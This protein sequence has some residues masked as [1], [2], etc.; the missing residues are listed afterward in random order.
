MQAQSGA[1]SMASIEATGPEVEAVVKKPGCGIE[2]EIALYNTPTQTVIA[3]VSK[4]VERVA[5]YF[6]QGN[7]KTKTLMVG[8]AFHSHYLDGML[9]EFRAVVRSVQFD[10]PLDSKL[11]VVSS[12]DGRVVEAGEMQKPEYWVDQVRSPVR[13]ID[14]MRTLAARGVDVFIEMGPQPV[15]S[16]MGAACLAEEDNSGMMEWLPSLSQNKDGV[17]TLLNGLSCLRLR[18]VDID[19][20]AYFAPLGCRRVQLPTYA[21]QRTFQQKPAEPDM[22]Y[23]R[24]A[25]G[26]TVKSIEDFEF[27][28]SWIP[29]K[30]KRADPGGTWGVISLSTSSW[31]KDVK[32]TL[33]QAGIQL[34][35][36][37]TLDQSEAKDRI[38]CLWDGHGEVANQTRD[39]I[40][41]ALA[42]LQMAAHM[43]LRCP[44][45]WV[46]R[47][48][49][50][51]GS[52]SDDQGM[53]PNSGSLLWGLMR[54]A[55]NEHPE[56]SLRLV[57]LGQ[58]STSEGMIS[59]L[60][61]DEEPE[62]VVRQGQ[63][64]VS[65][66]ERVTV[67]EKNPPHRG[68][69]RSNG[70]VLITGGLGHLGRHVARWLATKH[71]V[72]DMVLTSRHGMEAGIAME[73]VAELSA[74]NVAV[75]VVT[76]DIANRTTIASIMTAFPPDRPLRGVVHAAGVSDSGVLSSLTPERCNK[77]ISP[78]AH[79]AWL[80]HKATKDMELDF[81][82]MFS[83][84][85]GVMGMP[86]LANYAAAN[87]FLD[88]LA[89]LRRAQGLPATSVAFGTL[90]GDGGMA[91]RLGEGARSHLEQFGLDDL[92]AED[93]LELMG[94]AVLSGRPLTV[95]A[96]LDLKR[97]HGFYQDQGSGI[98]PLV[99]LLLA[100]Q[101]AVA[102]KSRRNLREILGET[103][104]TDHPAAMLGMVRETVAKAL[105]FTHVRDVDVDRSLRDIGV[106]SLTAVQIR[107][108]LATLTG[109]TIPVNIALLHP[110]L[111]ALSRALLSQF[112]AEAKPSPSPPNK[113][114]LDIE[115]ICQGSLDPSFRF[116]GP[117]VN[118]KVKSVFL[119]GV[120]GFVGAFILHPL[121]QRGITVHCLVRASDVPTA[122]RR[123]LAALKSYSISLS[124]SQKSNIV[125]IPG[126]VSKPLFGLLPETFS[127]LSEK[128]DAICHSAG[129]VDWMRPFEEYV[130]PNIVSTHE[131]LRLA[132][133][134]S[135]V[136]PSRTSKT[137][138]K[139]MKA[140][141]KIQIHQISTISTLPFHSATNP[142]TKPTDP[143][144]GYGTSKYLAERLVSGARWRGA[145]ATIYRL[146]YASACS[147]S[148]AFRRDRGDFLHGLVVGGLELGLFP[149]FSLDE[150]GGD[151]DMEIVLPVDYLAGRV[152][153]VMCGDDFEV[154]G[155]SEGVRG[156]DWDFR[157]G[158]GRAVGCNDFFRT[159]AR[160]GAELGFGDVGGKRMEI[161]RFGEW[162]RRALSYAAAH[163][164]SQLARISAVLDGYTEDTAIT[165]FKGERAGRNVFGGEL[166]PAPVLDEAW[167]R[168][169]LGCIYRDREGPIC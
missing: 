152:V 8:H 24:G 166:C 10:R 66:M 60:S 156:R 30:T 34:T 94:R 164:K 109:L 12:L 77:T 39:E 13:F 121:L 133:C 158:K 44:L 56:L 53:T 141:K 47:H 80:L 154:G 99:R 3:G 93:G 83:S 51:T 131:I 147:V 59:A 92:S 63:V 115:G 151:V 111:C 81:F 35:E 48:A 15:L 110:N 153:S 112:Q 38:I 97:L 79:G 22:Q 123:I 40:A 157:S 100:D 162:K 119:T 57:D 23:R 130:G 150:K 45:V 149:F 144:H 49:V 165:M 61:S 9:D 160:V 146:P 145:D 21:F 90:A 87:T 36:V 29:T 32:A 117:S 82:V 143:E 108:H 128:I 106:D 11:R 168:R 125:P 124:S 54:T 91:A 75:T 98:P 120:T 86:G 2:V 31:A 89:H 127:D 50:G 107:N 78:K 67:P 14:G 132:S 26:R 169:Y 155:G 116:D 42:Q 69:V 139:E 136:S 25:N 16:G 126:D 163:P 114:L 62:C 129:L 1:Y 103:N 134:C 159:V 148:G 41:E 70:A 137:N 28:V 118:S 122:L 46:T 33:S 105:G 18:H 19:W 37:E 161:V 101:I 4:G 74:M 17:S 6:A 167:V 55:G 68:F 102:P 7:R 43:Q 58:G 95:T 72:R 113:R 27:Q 5:N 138:T 52:A 142:P 71:H 85:S 135:S 96:S 88:A 84:I 65:R 20:E 140:R 104:P 76:G 73:F 64:L